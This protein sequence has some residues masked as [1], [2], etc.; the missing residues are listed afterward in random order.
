MLT[1]FCSYDEIKHLDH[2]QQLELIQKAKY[3]AYTTLNLGAQG[4]AF[5]VLSMI[6][7]VLGVTILTQFIST[8]I[9]ISIG[10]LTFLFSYQLLSKSIISKGLRSL[11][12]KSLLD[13]QS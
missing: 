8:S 4:I 5:L 11:M 12:A 7:A 9:A 10:I 3:E 6:I 2:Q 1:S 13:T